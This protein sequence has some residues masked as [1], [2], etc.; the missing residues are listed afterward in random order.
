MVNP[1]DFSDLAVNNKSQQSQQRDPND[2]SDLA[3]TPMQ[4]KNAAISDT[5]DKIAN[6]AINDHSIKNIFAGGNERNLTNDAGNFVLGAGDSVRNLLSNTA[7]LVTGVNIP[8][9]KSGSGN[10]Y[11]AGNIAGD[12]GGFVGGGEALDTVRVASEAIPYVG[13][14]AKYLGQSGI[15]SAIKRVLG[16]SGYGAAKNPNDRIL[17]AEE[18]LLGG[19]VSELS[20]Y[21]ISGISKSFN[22]LP[23]SAKSIYS[24]ISPKNYVKQIYDKV[25]EL[26]GNERKISNSKYKEIM[27]IA[28]DKKLPLEPSELDDTVFNSNSGLKKI[29]SQF[30][31]NPTIE[32]AH[33]LQSQ[34][35]SSDRS[36]SGKDVS[37]WQT[38]DSYQSTRKTLL[39]AISNGL[40]K[41][42]PSLANKYS[43]ASK[44]YRERVIPLDMTNRALHKIAERTPSNINKKLSSI[45][46]KDSYPSSKIGE[47]NIPKVPPELAAIQDVLRKTMRNKKIAITAATL[48]SLNLGKKAF[49]SIEGIL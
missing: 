45:P 6:S 28:G 4:S 31:D 35:G 5:L 17:G 10:S 3:A 18:G 8:E 21:A 32:N 30:K 37:T 15:P 41:E 25:P 16:A 24:K 36:L 49:E 48:G 47:K 44:H 9:A 27:D 20:P 2:F 14:A 39:D 42:D 19:S 46:L 33:N 23:N 38:K 26:L 22:A 1:N 40:N 7:N 12:I 29:Y 11:N 13:K 34:L 43:D